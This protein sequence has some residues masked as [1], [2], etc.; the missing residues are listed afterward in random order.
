MIVYYLLVHLGCARITRRPFFMCKIGNVVKIKEWPCRKHNCRIFYLNL[1]DF[2]LLSNQGQV[3]CI[4]FSSIGPSSLI[5]QYI[6]GSLS[7]LRVAMSINIRSN[8]FQIRT[9]GICLETYFFKNLSVSLTK[10]WHPILQYTGCYQVPFR[11]DM[12]NLVT[13]LEYS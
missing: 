6:V 5:L 4:R 12:S 11:E 2:L 9:Y 7:Y 3:C 1:F 8:V 10:L 13:T